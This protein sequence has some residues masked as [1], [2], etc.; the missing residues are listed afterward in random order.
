VNKTISSY[1]DGKEERIQIGKQNVFLRW[2]SAI[3]WVYQLRLG[4]GATVP[5]REVCKTVFNHML[6]SCMGKGNGLGKAR[7]DGNEFS[8]YRA[9]KLE[10]VE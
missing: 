7:F 4:P 9:E 8:I 10:E 3:G 2:V 1:C 6:T 5:G